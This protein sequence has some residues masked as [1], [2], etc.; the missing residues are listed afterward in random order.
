MKVIIIA[1]GSATRL[2][3]LTEKK[4]KGLLEINGK[5]IIERQIEIFRKHGI[6]EIFII[7]GPIKQF[8][9]PNVSYI[10]DAN[11]QDHDVLGSLMASENIFNGKIIT[12]Y[13]DVLFEDK[14]FEQ[15]LSFKG[16]IGIPVDLNWEKNY[17]DRKLHPKFEAENVLLKNNNIIKIK[18]NI[19][20][21]EPDEKIGE[22][23]GP[24]ILSEN[25]SKIFLETYK[26][27]LNT[28]QGHFHDAPSL[29]KAYLT[30]LIQELIDKNIQVE[31]II[32]DGKWC[33]IDTIEDLD[34]A[35][36]MF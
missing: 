8:G 4:P 35:Q 11:Y 33:E 34:K 21:C 30:D 15:F 12:S 9:I 17:V 31:P 3:K 36:K 23:L 19:S 24:L 14:I 5:S 13:S 20:D 27:L 29:Q 25:G 10:E 1:A 6:N 22:F 7:T 18:K 32:V 26:K 2:G 28:H 16:D